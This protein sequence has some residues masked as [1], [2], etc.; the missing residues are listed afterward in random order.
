[1]YRDAV[2]LSAHVK[3]LPALRS[4]S[5]FNLARE[6]VKSHGCQPFSSNHEIPTATKLLEPHALDLNMPS[7]NPAHFLAT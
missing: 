4:T 2:L 6:N 7:H 3:A 5:C 1:M